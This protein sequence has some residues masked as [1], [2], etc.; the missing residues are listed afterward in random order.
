MIPY[1]GF[2]GCVTVPSSFVVVRRN[3]KTF[4]SGNSLNA[5]K[6]G[7][8]RTDAKSIGYAA[9]YGASGAKLGKM[10]G[11]TTEEGIKMHTELS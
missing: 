2:I 1:K 11:K 6:L 10:L 3:G 9:L 7:I 8:S 5:K 4:V